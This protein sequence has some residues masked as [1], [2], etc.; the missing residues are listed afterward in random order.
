MI[1]AGMRLDCLIGPYFLDEVVKETPYSTMLETGLRHRRHMDLVWLQHDKP[2]A[3]FALS[4]RNVLNVFQAAGLVVVHRNLWHHW[5]GHHV[6]LILPPRAFPCGV[7]SR[8]ERLHVCTPPTKRCAELWETLLEML[9]HECSEACHRGYESAS[10]CVCNI[11]VHIRIHWTCSQEVLRWFRL[12]MIYYDCPLVGV[13]WLT[14]HSVQ[15]VKHKE[16]REYAS[17]WIV[18]RVSKISWPN[19]C[20]IRKPP[21]CNSVRLLAEVDVSLSSSVCSD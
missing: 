18:K 9:P 4:V 11:K 17:R 19:E 6:V 10:V 5:H 2:Q 8:E 20:F 7:V 3:H 1:W 16:G 21:P 14:R 12:I 15:Q 13:R